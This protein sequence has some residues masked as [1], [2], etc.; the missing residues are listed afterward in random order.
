MIFR[1]VPTPLILALVC[2]WGA[3]GCGPAQQ[4]Q[5]GRASARQGSGDIV[6]TGTVEEL[7]TA[8]GAGD[9][10]LPS[11]AGPAP[12]LHL[13]HSGSL[14]LT[15][16]WSPRSFRG[17]QGLEDAIVRH[18]NA[19]RQHKGLPRLVPDERLRVAARQH[20]REMIAKGYYSH[21]S[22]V[23]AWSTPSRRACLAGY[24]DP[25]VTENIGMVAGYPDPA[26]AM[27][28]SWRK[29]PGHYANMVEAKVTTI[30]VGL[31]TAMRNGRLHHFGTQLFATNL[32]DLRKL[33]VRPERRRVERL[34]VSIGLAPGLDV[35]AWMGR[36]FVATVPRVGSG[37]KFVTDLR[38]PRARSM[39]FDF[40]I[41]FGTGI[42]LV[43][44]HATVEKS[45]ATRVRQNS[46]DRRCRRLGR[47]TA[48]TRKL[49]VTR[50]LLSGEARAGTTAAVQTRYYLNHQWGPKMKL[51]LHKWVPF[52]QTLPGGHTRFSLVVGKIMKDLF[53]L[54]LSQKSPFTCP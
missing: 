35:K 43:C 24:F 22:P 38:L 30:G 32:L 54:D 39:T 26:H 19:L 21:T 10:I 8:T 12:S 37:A 13:E 47:V 5:D 23:A 44:V 40:A 51:Q 36:R 17:L 6:R 28:E 49:K 53:Q 20:T 33:V 48:R 42:P 15:P 2:G 45:G 46:F 4:P 25:Y 27:F 29:S 34:E 16:R 41:K 11:T 18:T 7:E 52:S 31:A 1:F 50:V 3:S 9:V 14:A